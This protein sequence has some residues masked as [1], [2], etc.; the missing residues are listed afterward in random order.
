MALKQVEL[1]TKKIHVF[2][3]SRHISLFTVYI[4]MRWNSWLARQVD[5]WAWI[6]ANMTDTQRFDG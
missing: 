3:F 1:Q 6:V 4:D 2:K 5:S